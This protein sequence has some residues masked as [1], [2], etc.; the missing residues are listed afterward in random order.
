MSSAS[1]KAANNSLFCAL[2]SAPTRSVPYERS[3]TTLSPSITDVSPLTGLR[4]RPLC[5]PR[6][7]PAALGNGTVMGD[8]NEEQRDPAEAIDDIREKR[9][10][11]DEPDSDE[12]EFLE[13][14]RVKLD[15]D[16]GDGTPVA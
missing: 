12:R 9:A 10:E 13:S 6:F 14:E 11:G 2:S 4:K 8:Q 7:S 1:R 15:P 16:E 5:P 3:E